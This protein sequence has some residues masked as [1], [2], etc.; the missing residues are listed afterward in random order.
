MQI[1]PTEYSRRVHTINTALKKDM[2]I[3]MV[4]K[5]KK[6]KVKQEKKVNESHNIWPSWSCAAFALM[7]L[8]IS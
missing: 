6:Q 8:S 5:Q 7:L 2:H 1:K 3:Y 4:L